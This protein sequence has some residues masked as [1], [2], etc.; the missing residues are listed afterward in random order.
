M[1]PLLAA[2]AVVIMAI[3]LALGLFAA[4]P[5]ALVAHLVLAMG[6]M[7]LILAAMAYFVPVLT[8]SDGAPRSVEGLAL[9]AWLGGLAM[10][11]SVAVHMEALAVALA[12]VGALLAVKAAASLLLWTILRARRSLGA[13]HP[14][15]AW[16]VA[17]LGFLLA[18]L[19]TVPLLWV[20][21]EQR[22]VLRLIHLHANLL[23]FVGLTAI[24]TLQVLLPT[25][26]N[27]WD[28]HAATRLKQDLGFGIC[29]VAMMAIGAGFSSLLAGI[30]AALFLVPLL[31]M[32]TRWSMDYAD[33]L[34]RLHGASTALGLS[35]FG[36]V[37]LIFAGL[38]HAFGYLNGSDAL[39]GFVPAFLLPL[40]SGAAMQL[41]PVWLRPGRQDGWHEKLR[42]TLGR[43]SGLHA[44]LLVAG[45]LAV[46]FGYPQGL[47]LA[48]VGVLVLLAV[49]VNAL[50]KFCRSDK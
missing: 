44:P 21:P 3:A 6:I 28:K 43:Y 26:A 48:A 15:L 18:A 4:L 19:V 47:W 2:N 9:L 40:V 24:G 38:G 33:H 29:G 32:G 16:Y 27:R 17:A 11:A 37:G 20:W 50:S 39:T 14:G 25:A 46:A 7:P 34:G 8:R 13:P 36:L 30:G 10:V 5:S 45:G 35:C 1:L 12:L 41:L 49:V 31:R 22:V 23:G 42:S